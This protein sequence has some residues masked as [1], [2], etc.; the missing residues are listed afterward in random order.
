MLRQWQRRV[1]VM[2]EARLLL[3]LLLLLQL[4][5]ADGP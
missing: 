5:G 4:P 3:L 2:R 1:A